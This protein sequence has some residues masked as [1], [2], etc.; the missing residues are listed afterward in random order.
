MSKPSRKVPS[1]NEAKQ[2]YLLALSNARRHLTCAEVLAANDQHGAAVAHLALA[3]EETIKT[4]ALFMVSEG[5]APREAYL[6]ALLTQHAPR[7]FLGALMAI[8]EFFATSWIPMITRLNEEFPDRSSETYFQTR[9]ERVRGFVAEL[10]RIADAPVGET[11]V[12]FLDWWGRAD[13][14]KQRGLYVDFKEGIWIGPHTVTAHV[15]STSH[16]IVESFV[17]KIEEAAEVVSRIPDEERARIS[18]EVR[19]SMEQLQQATDRRDS[20]TEVD[21]RPANNP[22]DDTHD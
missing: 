2:G 4:L 8:G 13:A 20:Q 14:L 12:G 9:A 3:S 6:R 7:Q 15:Y 19:E 16:E 22:R 10:N 17:T 11:G 21:G 5:L 18:G 1:A